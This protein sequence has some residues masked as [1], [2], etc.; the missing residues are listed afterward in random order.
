MKEFDF[1]K[2]LKDLSTHNDK[3]IIGIG[4]D[5]ALIGDFFLA[6]DLLG[7]GCAF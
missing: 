5:A 4:D 2:L 1:I 3:N 7:A 6:K